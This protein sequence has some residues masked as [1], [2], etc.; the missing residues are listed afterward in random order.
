MQNDARFPELPVAVPPALLAASSRSFQELQDS[1]D[2]VIAW[3]DRYAGPVRSSFHSHSRGQLIF[4]T[5]M[6]AA[7]ETGQRNWTMR[8]GQGMWL[9]GGQKHRVSAQADPVFCSIYVRPDLAARLPVRCGA[10]EISPYL[11][12]LIAKLAQLYRGRVDP[13]AYPHLVALIFGE[14]ATS[15]VHSDCLPMPQDER[16]LRL[17]QSLVD[18]PGDRRTLA[19]WARD[20]GASGRTLERLFR[21][22]TGMTF[23]AWRQTCRAL[24]AIPLLE[25]DLPVQRVA[26]MC[27]YDSQ[28][29]FAAIF[30]RVTGLLPASFRPGR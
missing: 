10:M 13:A 3:A 7:V 5:E 9:P 14:L 22:E 15:S 8:A 29:A 1:N 30:R 23:V 27:G 18:R 20:I 2:P 26:W 11:R 16:L 19:A 6:P 12:E 21:E 4:A 24:A 25:A 17:C 28:S